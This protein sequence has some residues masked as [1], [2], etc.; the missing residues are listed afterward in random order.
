MCLPV[1]EIEVSGD[2]FRRHHEHPPL[3]ARAHQVERHVQPRRGGRAAEAHVEGSARRAQRLLDFDGDRRIG[4]LLVRCGADH[5][6]DLGRFDSCVIERLLRRGDAEFGHDGQFVVA[7]L[8]NAR[9]HAV[10]VEDACGFE[11]MPVFHAG[12]IF[13]EFD[14]GTRQRIEALRLAPDILFRHPGVEAGHQL[15][16]GDHRFGDFHPDAADAGTLQKPG[17][18]DRFGPRQ[19]ALVN[20]P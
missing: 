17:I 7:A 9:R 3:R 4:P 20:T 2:D 15:V 19:L 8:G 5:H 6:V 12:C 13:D 1:A 11:H 16:I 18:P 10:G 14:A